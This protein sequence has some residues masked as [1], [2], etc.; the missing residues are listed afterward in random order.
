MFDTRRHKLLL[1]EASSNHFPQDSVALLPQL[2]VIIVC[3]H[4]LLEC[5][6]IVELNIAQWADVFG[7]LAAGHDCCDHRRLQ[8]SPEASTRSGGGG[9]RGTCSH[10]RRPLD[11]ATVDQW[12]RAWQ[13]RLKLRLPRRRQCRQWRHG[14]FGRGEGAKQPVDI[15]GRREGR[16]LREGQVET[17]HK[18]VRQRDRD[19]QAVSQQDHLP[20]VFDGGLHLTIVH[21]VKEKLEVL[22]GGVGKLHSLQFFPVV[23]LQQLKEVR[24]K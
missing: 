22:Q 5:G 24:Q 11:P 15:D 3:L 17:G 1:T 23:G 8:F 9:G 20:E 6:A 18:V 14:R 19:V 16:Q 10:R 7:I 13:S 12:G 21:D 2:L 4:V